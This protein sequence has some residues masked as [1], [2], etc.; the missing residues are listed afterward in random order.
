MTAFRV[1]TKSRSRW[2]CGGKLSCAYS[3]TC[4]RVS[5]A[6]GHTYE[7][8][9]SPRSPERGGVNCEKRPKFMAGVP[10]FIVS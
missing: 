8:C 2:E 3:G 10:R 9:R 4:S 5:Q 7:D 6:G 1:S